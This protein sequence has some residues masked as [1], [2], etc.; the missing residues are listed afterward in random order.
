M[1]LLL[2]S[3]DLVLEFSLVTTTRRLNSEQNQVKKSIKLKNQK[4]TQSGVVRQHVYF[5]VKNLKTKNK[6]KKPMKN[7]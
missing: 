5:Y 2:I 3:R 7:Q 1:F 4:E 6:N